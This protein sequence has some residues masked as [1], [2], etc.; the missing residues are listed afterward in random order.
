ML[1]ELYVNEVTK[2]WQIN[3]RDNFLINNF[4]LNMLFF[5]NSQVIFANTE[6]NLQRVTSTLNKMANK[7]NLKIS[8]T[9]PN[10]LGFKG[11]NH[12]RAKI[13]TGNNKSEQVSSF[14]YF[15]RN[16]S[17][18]HSKDPE[19]KLQNTYKW[20]APQKTLLHKVRTDI[21]KKFYQTVVTPIFYITQKSG[22]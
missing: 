6:D 18:L 17:Y 15:G 19:T 20:Q 5:A 9:K 3:L 2:K 7:Y 14:N 1:F 22:Y 21:I 13:I 11:E 8:T 4:P 16:I 10:V 12:L